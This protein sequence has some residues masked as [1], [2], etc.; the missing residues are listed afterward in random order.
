MLRKL[1]E[2][3]TGLCPQCGRTIPMKL[4]ER[5]DG[6]VWFDKFCPD[7]GPSE[8]RAYSS[9]AEYA[10]HRQVVAPALIPNAFAGDATKP[11]P[12]GCG[13][14]SRHEQHLCMP[15]VEVTSRCN[16]ACPICLNSS[17]GNSPDMTLAEFNHILD[18][19]LEAEDQIDLL[20]I[21]GGEPLLHP[22]I[23]PIVD[24]A[25]AREGVVKVSISTN[26]LLLLENPLLLRELKKR[27]VVLSLQFDGF[28]EEV[29]K[30]MRGRE[31]NVFHRRLFKVLTMSDMNCSITFTLAGEWNAT[32]LNSAFELLF[33]HDN[34]VSMMI[35]PMAF[36]GRGSNLRGETSRLD[37]A[38]TLKQID[39]YGAPFV[40]SRDFAPL[41]CSHPLCFS[42][43]Y[44]LKLDSGRFV[45]LNKII[46]A[47]TLLQQAANKVVFGLNADE[48]G[49]LKDMVY[50]L[51]A[52]SSDEADEVLTTLK[53]LLK[54]YT[55]PKTQ[56]SCKCFNPRQAFNLMEREI[57]SVYIHAFMDRDTFDLVRVRRCCQAY[58]LPD[59]RLIP[60]CVRNN[61]N[62]EGVG[63]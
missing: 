29:N 9:A 8:V 62:A 63:R 60:C 11:C 21:S 38:A 31:L 12:E 10:A 51:W 7:C 59:G 34:I 52:E 18:K 41:P 40:A 4:Q 14:C 23:L 46:D 44:F 15:I 55:E 43:A 56:C 47:R 54:N 27:D 24:A 17:G 57:K 5:E 20:N 22:R 45:P 25:L 42:L 61:V 53:R 26:G 16:M 30:K 37:I 49:E 3:G 36:T 50:Q 32:E 48:H 2:V 58:A 39:S 33:T 1:I 6:A 35:Q 19:L 28:N 13:F